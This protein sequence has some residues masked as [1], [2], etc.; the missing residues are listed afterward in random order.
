MRTHNV[1]SH[2]SHQCTCLHH[3]NSYQ[4]WGIPSGVMMSSN[5]ISSV[6]YWYWTRMFCNYS[7]SLTKLSV[8]VFIFHLYIL[9]S[10][11][12]VK[13]L[14]EQNPALLY[15]RRLTNI[16]RI[17]NYTTACVGKITSQFTQV[18]LDNYG[19]ICILYIV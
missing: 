3:N 7:M 13:N 14:S 19:R 2:L 10:S 8:N 16:N 11:L 4:S 12:C 9:R 17:V 18:L 1:P 5:H 6:V 15:T